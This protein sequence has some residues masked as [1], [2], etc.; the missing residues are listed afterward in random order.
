MSTVAPRIGQRLQMARAQVE[1]ATV[2]SVVFFLYC[3]FVIDYFARFAARLPVY[4]QF[5]PT[6]VMAMVL[7]FAAFLHADKFREVMREPT[8]RILS[9]F[10]LYLVVSFP[11]VE[12]PGSIIR[13]NLPDF[14][15]AAVFLFFTAFFVDT[16]RRLKVFFA[17]FLGLQFLRV[18]EPLFMNWTTGYL[19][20][21][22]HLWGGEFMGRLTGAPAD[23][24]D[25][26]GLAFVIATC[27]AYG[28]FMLWWSPSKWLKIA[29]LAFVPAALYGMVLTQ[30]RGGFIALSVGAIVL[31]WYTRHKIVFLILVLIMAA[32]VWSQMDDTQRDRYRSLVDTETAQR[33]GVDGRLTGIKAEFRLG[34]NRPIFGHGLGTTAE[35]KVNFGGG[36]PQAAHNVY[37]E[38]LIETGLIG[39][40]IFSAFLLSCYFLLLRNIRRFRALGSDFASPQNYHFRMNLAFMAVFWLYAVF[41]FNYFGLSQEYWYLFAG[42][43]VAFSRSIFRNQ[44][45][46]DAQQKDLPLQRGQG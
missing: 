14:V 20:G 10:L 25:H 11:L 3:Y 23:V 12:W 30:S 41:S 4:A 24:I 15:R 46:L 13:H 5:R 44:E 39:F 21:R 2:P 34:L 22:Y 45:A 18:L 26:N 28:Y 37:A 35:A 43:C 7:I 36:R 29:Y 6:L 31:L 42:L 8:V 32:G 40:G 1:Q 16:D 19:G 17:L 9:I 33:A 38:A 27:L